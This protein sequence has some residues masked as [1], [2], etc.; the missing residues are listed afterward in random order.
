MW[1]N[2]YTFYL[3]SRPSPLETLSLLQRPFTRTSAAVL[4]S[5]MVTSAM[6]RQAAQVPP[7]GL[8]PFPPLGSAMR[9]PWPGHAAGFASSIRQIGPSP[10]K[11][12]SDLTKAGA[13]R[14]VSMFRWW[15]EDSTATAAGVM[16]AVRALGGTI[17]LILLVFIHSEVGVACNRLLHCA[18]LCRSGC[19]SRAG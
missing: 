2:C 15:V 4:P 12:P 5:L 13:H 8:R 14:R 3:G 11:G 10:Y 6:G 16:G 19:A 18:L 17:L 1:P 9:V 7:M